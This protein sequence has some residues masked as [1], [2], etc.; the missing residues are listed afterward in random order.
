MKTTP[1]SYESIIF[2]QSCFYFLKIQVFS[3]SP[4]RV[5]M[6]VFCWTPDNQCFH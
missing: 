6:K 3:I 2:I 1:H 5:D 4:I